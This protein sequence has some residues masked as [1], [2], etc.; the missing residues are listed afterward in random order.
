MK[1]QSYITQTLGLLQKIIRDNKKDIV[2]KFEETNFKDRGP[3]KYKSYTVSL[4]G[5]KVCQIATNLPNS[6]IL[7]KVNGKDV[8]GDEPLSNL[9]IDKAYALNDMIKDVYLA[10]SKTKVTAKDN[11]EQLAVTNFLKQFEK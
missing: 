3:L 8:M 5:K 2:V 1:S 11:K 7:L 6:D 4:D 10:Q 9:N